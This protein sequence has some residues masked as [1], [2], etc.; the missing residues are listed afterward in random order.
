MDWK[1]KGSERPGET[2][3]EGRLVRVEPVAWPEPG[4]ELARALAEEDDQLWHYMKIGP[5]AGAD[6]AANCVRVMRSGDQAPMAIRSLATGEVI[7][8]A[9]FLRIRPDDGSAEL[10]SIAYGRAM[11]RSPMGTEAML[12]MMSHLFDD[13]GWR[14]CEWRCNAQNERS[15]RAAER[16]GF[17]FEGVFRQDHWIKGR[18]RDTAWFSVIDGEWPAVRGALEKWLAPE[19]FDT[20]GRQIRT[21]EEVR[22][23]FPE[24]T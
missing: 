19:N 6:E 11:Q 12:L 17:V 3:L 9:S 14:R 13:L 10:G 16:L 21:L 4:E 1:P 20:D 5:F 7:G 24:A 15:Y 22:S 2:V 18:N 8:M 23:Q